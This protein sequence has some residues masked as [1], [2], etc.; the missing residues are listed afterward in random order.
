MEFFS[1]FF[2]SGH[3]MLR[4]FLLAG[5]VAVTHAFHVL[6]DGLAPQRLA[7][8]L[9]VCMASDSNKD[10]YQ[11]PPPHKT[12]SPPSPEM[13]NAGFAVTP[14]DSKVCAFD[15]QRVCENCPSYLKYLSVWLAYSQS[16]CKPLAGLQP[17]CCKPLAGGLQ[18]K[19]LTAQTH[20]CR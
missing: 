17:K 5:L 3:H 12:P 8:K 9:S 11:P 4:T 20:A 18:P 7:R 13:W 15:Q 19:W 16:G 6:P 2:P 10:T 1:F 14:S